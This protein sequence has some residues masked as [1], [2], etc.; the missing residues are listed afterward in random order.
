MFDAARPTRYTHPRRHR[1]WSRPA[2]SAKRWRVIGERHRGASAMAPGRPLVFHFY[3]FKFR[4]TDLM[5][6]KDTDVGD[7]PR[8]FSIQLGDPSRNR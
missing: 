8:M 1:P 4:K 6:V 2:S 3:E 5:T 7:V